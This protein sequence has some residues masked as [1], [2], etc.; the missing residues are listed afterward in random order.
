MIILIICPMLPWPI[1]TGGDQAVFNM[2]NHLQHQC[3]IHFLYPAMVSPINTQIHSIWNQVTFHPFIK[4]RNFNLVT[5]RIALKIFN[6]FRL[7]DKKCGWLQ[8]ASNFFTP[9]F[10]SFVETVVKE[11]KP[12]IIQTE[13]YNYQDLVFALPPNVKKIF[14]QHEIH[15]VINS[16]RLS[17]NTSIAKRFAFN[18]LKSEEIAAMNSYDAILTLTDT[19][20]KELQDSGVTVPIYSSPAGIE[21]PQ[22]RNDCI[23]TNKLIFVGGSG[24]TPNLEG[25]TWFI[26]NVW[27]NII[28]KHP[29]VSLN[30]IGKWNE[31]S[32]K[33]LSNLHSNI[34]FK[35][36]VS[37][38]QDEYNG[39]IAI[40][41]ILRGSGMRM[42]IIDAVNFGSP[43]VSTSIGAEGL[44]YKN[45]IDC[46]IADSPD[47]FAKRVNELIENEDLRAKFYKK[48]AETCEKY[49]SMKL[50]ANNRMNLYNKVLLS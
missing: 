17:L 18:K 4:S 27:G 37:N 38:L 49:Y 48:S 26:N 14:I 10:L 8:S 47:E 29:N 11:I 39:A 6:Q 40:V 28:Q 23:F 3:N 13:F 50:L 32:I 41:P 2:V 36:F 33:S 1:K 44:E 19:D 5:S 46:F 16:Q 15:Y 45:S 25:I 7:G 43:F 9:E 12:D 42:K 20:K 24:H 31:K 21:Q 35:G 30:I 34:Y 22:I